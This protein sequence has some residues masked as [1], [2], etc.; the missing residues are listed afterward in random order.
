MAW[1]LN[2]RWFDKGMN[3]VFNANGRAGVNV[4]H[5]CIDGMVSCGWAFILAFCMYFC[6]CLLE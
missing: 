5:T 1:F 3:F 4:G 2:G 6:R